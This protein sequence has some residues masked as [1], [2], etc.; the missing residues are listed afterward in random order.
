MFYRSLQNRAGFISEL[1]SCV[2]GRFLADLS[3][4]SFLALINSR[5][6]TF[7]TH[8]CSSACMPELSVGDSLILFC[9]GNKMNCQYNE[10]HL[11]NWFSCCWLCKLCSA[12]MLRWL[13]SVRM[14]YNAFLLYWYLIITTW[15]DTD[16]H[17]IESLYH[18]N[19][20]AQ[21][22]IYT[23]IPLHTYRTHIMISQ[24]SVEAHL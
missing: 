19:K 7:S 9:Y 11:F 1:I 2:S 24:E 22:D 4:P 8:W 14:R 3:F 21:C 18:M 13:C 10:E 20:H 5:S 15:G 17:M 23:D 16:K 12:A 6:V